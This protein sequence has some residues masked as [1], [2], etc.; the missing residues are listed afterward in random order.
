[1]GKSMQQE[2]DDHKQEPYYIFTDE[3]ADQLIMEALEADLSD[4]E[5]LVKLLLILHDHI[6]ESRLQESVYLL[7]KAAFKYS[8]VHSIHFRE[9]LE[10]IRQ[11]QNPAEEARARKYG[12]HDSE[13]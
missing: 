8:I 5:P 9:Y 3:E 13:A 1:M 11:D 7:M 10:A 6:Q 12:D 2:T 4:P